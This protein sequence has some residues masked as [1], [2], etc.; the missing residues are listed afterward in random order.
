MGINDNDILKD[1]R[2]RSFLR[3]AFW[4]F[5]I[6]TAVTIS[7]FIVHIQNFGQ[8]HTKVDELGE[9]DIA[10][11]NDRFETYQGNKVKGHEVKKLCKLATTSNYENRFSDNQ[12]VRVGVVAEQDTGADFKDNHPSNLVKEKCKTGQYGENYLKIEDTSYYSIKCHYKDGL[13]RSVTVADFK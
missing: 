7:I 9:A 4:A 12:Q 8:E 6:V 3:I 2:T 13:V 5:I 11:F 1:Q 10:V